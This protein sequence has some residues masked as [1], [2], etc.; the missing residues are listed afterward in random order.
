MY[1]YKVSQDLQYNPNYKIWTRIRHYTES[2]RH[3]GHQYNLNQ[4]RI[5]RIVQVLLD[6]DN[7]NEI[8]E[9]LEEQDTDQYNRDWTNNK[10]TILLRSDQ[11]TLTETEE[12]TLQQ[13][14]Q[15]SFDISQPD[16]DTSKAIENLR[17]NFEEKVALCLECLMAKQLTEL[18]QNQG[19]YNECYQDINKLTLSN[20]PGEESSNSFTVTTEVLNQPIEN[21]KGK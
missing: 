18:D 1:A 15:E 20:D 19:Y 10:I 11:I 3:A 5:Y 2:T 9:V 7:P 12:A 8:T 13:V 17:K 6:D 14:L 4:S 16:F 21:I